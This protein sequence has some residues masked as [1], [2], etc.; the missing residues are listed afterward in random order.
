MQKKKFLIILLLIPV[1]FVAPG[2]SQTKEWTLKKCIEYANNE[3]IQIKQNL[4]SNKLIKENI[5]QIKA[6]RIPSLNAGAGQSFT[7]GASMDP[8]TGDYQNEN[9][10]SNNFNLS[11]SLVLFNG[12]KNTKSIK[13][14]EVN[15]QAAEYKTEQIKENISLQI[16]NAYLNILYAN[17][18]LKNMTEQVKSTKQQLGRTEIMV[19]AG[20]LP[21]SDLLEMKAQ[22]SSDK[23]AQTNAE[24]Q[25]AI[26]KVILMQLMELPLDEHFKIS[27]PAIDNLLL[28]VDKDFNNPEKI[29][30]QALKLKPEIKNALLN[31]KSKALE[32]DI[33]K[34]S[35]YPRLTLNGSLT[36]RY[37]SA[38]KL[39]DVSVTFWQEE[40]IGYLQSDPTQVVVAMKPYHNMTAKDYC[41][42]DQINDNFFQSV[43]LNLSIPIFNNRQ[44]KSNISRAII[45]KKISELEEQSVKNDLRKKIEQAWLDVKAARKEYLANKEQY[46]SVKQSY[47]N[48]KEKFNIGMMNSVDFLINK[49]KFIKAENS[50]LNAKFNYVFKVKILDFYSGKPLSL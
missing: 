17:E 19:K 25:L 30:S 9:Y 2:Y 8:V 13:Q 6:N 32:I 7:W 14:S 44:S 26:A 27:K 34:S 10:S 5:S 49:T 16:T 3:N 47:N 1:L 37:S 42:F 48:S 50:L 40:E 36:S 22:Y 43:S 21:E 38:R 20:M 41:F 18:N 28:K 31:T 24:N 15:Y 35:L 33:A 45:N 4:L 23:L 46:A 39:Y 11:S 29:Y 12:L